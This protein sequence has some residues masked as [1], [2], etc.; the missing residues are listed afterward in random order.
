MNNALCVN[1]DNGNGFQCVCSEGF[2]GD[3]CDAVHQEKIMR[4]SD[5][6]LVVILICLCNALSK[7]SVES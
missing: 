5:K 2:S 4:L 1:L 7:C 6:A 3:L